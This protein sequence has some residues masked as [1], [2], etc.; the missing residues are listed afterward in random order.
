MAKCPND[1]HA[2]CDDLCYAGGCLHMPGVK[3]LIPCD[4]CGATITLDGED[5]FGECACQAMRWEEFW[6]QEDYGPFVPDRPG[7]LPRDKP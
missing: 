4:G 6:M 2:C 3:P 7:I 5:I 1:G